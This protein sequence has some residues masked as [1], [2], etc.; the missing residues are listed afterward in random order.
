MGATLVDEQGAINF[1]I[2][3]SSASSVSLVLFSED[4]LQAGRTT[5]KIELDPELNRTGSVWHIMLPKL[6]TTLLYGF[7]MGGRHQDKDIDAPG[8][9]GHRYDEGSVL[10]DPYATAIIGRRV[11]GQLGPYGPG[12]ALGLART[13]PQAA[14]VLPTPGTAFDWEGDRPLNLPLEDLVI[15]EMHVRGFTWDASS[16][17]SSPGTFAGMTERLDY[18]TTLGINA[19]ELQ[20]VHEFNELEYYQVRTDEYRYNYWGYS[21]VGFFAPMARYSAAAAA[22]RPGADIVN[23][24]KTLVK[25]C[26]RRG[27]EVI[28]DVVFNHTAEGNE[29][30]PSISFRGLDNRVY[31][32]LAPEGQYYNYSGCGNTLNCNHPVVRKFVLDALRYW[33]VEMHVDGFRF[34]LGSIMTRAHSL[35][36]PSLPGDDPT[37]TPQGIIPDGS[38]VPTGT[39]LSDPP[40]V[41]MIS[42]DPVLRNTKLIAEAWDCDGLFQVG[43]FPHYGGRW[44]EWNGSFRDTV[45]QFIK[46]TEGPFASAFA[47]AVCGSPTIYAE[48]EPGEGDWWGNNGGRQ[49]RG[50]RGPQHSINFITAH[51]GFTLA[52]LVAFNEKKNQ[53]NGEGNRDGENHNLS[54]NC[55][56]EGDTRKPS[57]VRLRAR[58]MRNLAAAL[59]LSHGTPMIL[60][61]DE[62]GHS[63]G[64]NNNTYCHDSALNWFSWDQA[65][66]DP[67]GY[68]RYFRHL[69]HFRRT[70]AELRRSSFVHA[71]AIAWHGKLPNEPDWT[72]ES[73]LVAYTLS[74]SSGGGL[75]IAFNTSHKGQIVQ[76]PLWPNRTWQ[77]ISDSGQIAPFDFLVPDEILS[78]EEVAT[79]R[80]KVSMWLS[81]GMYAM[82]PYSSLLL[83]S[84]PD[85]DT[86]PTSRRATAFSAAAPA[87]T[88]RSNGKA[89]SGVPPQTTTAA[90]SSPPPS[91][92]QGPQSGPSTDSVVSAAGSSKA[93]HVQSTAASVLSNAKALAAKISGSPAQPSLEASS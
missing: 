17:V 92:S 59:L 61:G 38:G 53:R 21:T 74:N 62:Y 13:W 20:P 85:L 93:S 51:D 35:W 1:A 30:G 72:E 70:H 47:S 5:H 22:G 45:R 12:G 18:L 24:F 2:Y 25:E 52:D 8:A 80:Q 16:K 89:G 33:V 71:G 49:W 75:Y 79:A 83:E 55:G 41:E 65:A 64:G 84:V 73:R 56:V 19:I 88:A 37:L 26:H 14:C 6:D 36:H 50:G 4:D 63:K 40:L 48:A 34:D 46:G 27:I 86:M 28:L 78:E 57:V 90:A 69:V 87:V 42:E 11:F 81:D 3:A 77:L 44:A 10:L 91:F 9:A 82:L 58:Q 31:Y 68:A 32:M 39:P 43:A 60:M 7:C 76:L 29:N 23:E 54:W 67:T 66:T 15:Y